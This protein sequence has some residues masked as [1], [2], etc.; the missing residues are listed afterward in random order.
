MPRTIDGSDSAKCAH[1]YWAHA[2]VQCPWCVGFTAETADVVPVRGP[3]NGWLLRRGQTPCMRCGGPG[4]AG[5]GLLPSFVTSAW[6][7]QARPYLKQNFC[8]GCNTLGPGITPAER[9]R[10]FVLREED[11]PLEVRREAA[12]AMKELLTQI[13]NAPLLDQGGRDAEWPPAGGERF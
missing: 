2:H 11:V 3:G 8:Y 1:G 5:S 13:H 9:A 12:A 10:L 6:W 4:N 7:D